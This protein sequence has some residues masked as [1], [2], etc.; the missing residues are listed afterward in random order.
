MS[1]GGQIINQIW[2]H[3]ANRSHRFSALLRAAIWQCHKRLLGRP[4]DLKYHGLKLRCQVDSRSAARALYFSGLPDYWEMR[5][6]QDYLH[7][8]DVFVDAGANVGV[9]TLLA[10]SLVGPEG[11]IHCFEPNGKTV[12]KLQENIELNRLRNVSVHQLGLG[13]VQRTVAFELG[14]DDCTSHIVAGISGSASKQIPLVRLDQQLK[15]TDIALAKFDIEGYEPF[16]IRGAAGLLAEGN[17]PV[18]LIEVGGLANHHGVVTS[19]FIAEL[20]RLGYFTAIYQPSSH[21]LV[22]T[23]RPWEIPVEN[24]LAISKNRRQYVD[25]RLRQ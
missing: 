7:P 21:E 11:Y 9:Y 1:I 13:D 10:R 19:D 18:M 25:A 23:L 16:A 3:P 14:A 24:V 17:P 6:M 2:T 5:F 12:Q 22:P 8:A 4:K 20:D 15:D